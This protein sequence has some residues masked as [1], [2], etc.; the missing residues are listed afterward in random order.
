M[1]SA[2]STV[3]D[4]IIELSMKAKLGIR[5]EKPLAVIAALKHLS[6]TE[7]KGI[8][9][10]ALFDGPR[11]KSIRSIFLDL[12]DQYSVIKEPSSSWDTIAGKNRELQDAILQ[13]GTVDEAFSKLTFEEIEV[14]LES[15][16][17]KL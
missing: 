16:M 11:A 12:A 3:V 1:F 13:F 8:S 2:K 5:G 9:L 15:Y 4:F 6:E 14:L 10:L 7:T 17:R